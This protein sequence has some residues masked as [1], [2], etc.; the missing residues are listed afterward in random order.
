MIH[1]E[2]FMHR[3]SFVL[4]HVEMKTVSDGVYRLQV[5]ANMKGVFPNFTNKF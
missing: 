4:L 5:H 2:K 1:D 3:T